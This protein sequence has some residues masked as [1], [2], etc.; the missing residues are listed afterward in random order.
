M[1]AANFPIMLVSLCK[2]FLYPF[3]IPYGKCP[4]EKAGIGI[5]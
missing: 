3:I 5:N 2:Y 4:V 1:A